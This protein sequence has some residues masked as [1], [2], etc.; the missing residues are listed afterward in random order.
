MTAKI[1]TLTPISPRKNENS[2]AKQESSDEMD[3]G[4]EGA[5]I[6]TNGSIIGYN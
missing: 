5:V 4:G 3:V 6:E 1:D 2:N